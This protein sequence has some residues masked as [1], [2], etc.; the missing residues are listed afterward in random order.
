[1]PVNIIGYFRNII[2]YNVS[3]FYVFLIAVSL[4]IELRCRA[5]K[6]VK[7]QFSKFRN[8]FFFSNNTPDTPIGHTKTMET[9]DGKKEHQ[10]AKKPGCERPAIIT[11]LEYM[12]FYLKSS[13]G[14]T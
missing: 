7:R 5:Q 13:E 11:H 6:F 14:H 1:M 10:L 9:S 12:Q 4:N 2:L 8:G 3:I